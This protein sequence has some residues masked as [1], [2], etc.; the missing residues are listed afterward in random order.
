LLTV[1]YKRTIFGRPESGRFP[2][3]GVCPREHVQGV[4][5]NHGD[6]HGKECSPTGHNERYQTGEL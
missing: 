5:R 6:G 1:N 3:Q 2:S 4:E